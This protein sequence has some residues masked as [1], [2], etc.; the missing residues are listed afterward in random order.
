MSKQNKSNKS[1][2]KPKHRIRAVAIVPTRYP[3]PIDD[4]VSITTHTLSTLTAPATLPYTKSGLIVLG[5]GTDATGYSFL[6]SMSSLFAAMGTCYSRFMVTDLKVT[7]RT[8][9]TTYSSGGQYFVASYVPSDANAENPPT[10]ED[11][12]AQARHMCVST[13]GVSGS[14]RVNPSDYYN[15]WKNVNDTDDGDKQA[16]VVQYFGST[17]S[18]S[19]MI[20]VLEIEVTVAF[21]GLR[22]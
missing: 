2:Q 6:S 4:V 13:P 10:N 22:K 17:S 3:R 12:V 5:K 19:A 9:A 8:P 1:K 7:A 11:E 20:S 15:D 18:G 21:C 14:F 16:G